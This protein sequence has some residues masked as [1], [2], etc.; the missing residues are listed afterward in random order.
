M[1]NTVL[2]EDEMQIW[3]LYKNTFKAIFSRITKETYDV[4]GISEGD[5][6][7]LDL[8]TNA[9]GGQLRQQE[10]ADKMDWSRS[11]LSHHLTRMEKRGLIVKR[12]VDKGHGYKVT[13][14]PQGTSALQA[15]WPLHEKG[16]KEYFIEK[17][18]PPDIESITRLAIATQDGAGPRC[19]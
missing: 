8:V 5:F 11:R 9:D 4:V 18:T 14:T 17:L 3:K 13:I 1:S 10:L 12:A 19:L 2:T 7:V 6:M 16:I 15:T